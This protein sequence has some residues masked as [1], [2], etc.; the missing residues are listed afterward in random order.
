[1]ST[2]ETS[3]TEQETIWRGNDQRKVWIDILLVTFA[4]VPVRN[5]GDEM[6]WQTAMYLSAERTM[7][8]RELVIW[9]IEVVVK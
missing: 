3:H 6:G 5:R 2:A 1:M 9:L 8:K 7:R 4:I